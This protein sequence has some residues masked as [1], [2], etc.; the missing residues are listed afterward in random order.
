MKFTYENRP[1]IIGNS[2]HPLSGEPDMIKIIAPDGTYELVR[3]NERDYTVYTGFS[4]EVMDYL[5]A[6]SEAEY[7][8][9][10]NGN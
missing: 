7:I 1:A 9:I 10:R 5:D 4:D 6:L 2:D 3:E 8:A